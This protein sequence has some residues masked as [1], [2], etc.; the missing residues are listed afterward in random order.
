MGQNCCSIKEDVSLPPMP[1]KIDQQELE[2]VREKYKLR[3]LPIWGQPETAKD[4]ITQ[5]FPQTHEDV[6]RIIFEYGDDFRLDYVHFNWKEGFVPDGSNFPLSEVR[7]NYSNQKKM[8]WSKAQ[9][10][11]KGVRLV[12]PDNY[13]TQKIT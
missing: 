4:V 9:R 3:L 13:P 2:R 10:Q 6:C 12:N 5:Q 1:R 7:A 8:L 11:S